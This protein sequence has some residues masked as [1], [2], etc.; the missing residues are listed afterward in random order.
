M[1][2]LLCLLY[3]K[4]PSRA[5]KGEVCTARH[6]ITTPTPPYLWLRLNL[7]LIN[8]SHIQHGVGRDKRRGFLKWALW[9]RQAHAWTG[10][11]ASSFCSQRGLGD[12]GRVMASVSLLAQA[13]AP[14]R[15][16]MDILNVL[17]HSH[18][19]RHTNRQLCSSVCLEIV[20]TCRCMCCSREYFCSSECDDWH[21]LLFLSTH[22]HFYHPHRCF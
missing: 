6:A 12:N 17:I 14:T 3:N 9:K 13:D 2:F 19:G 18:K 21:P 7:K 15:A 8:Q 20:F 16:H 5:K 10:T 11:K 1:C 4:T 22:M